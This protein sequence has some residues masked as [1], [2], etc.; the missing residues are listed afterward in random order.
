MFWGTLQN[1]GRRGEELLNKLC[2]YCFLCTQK[3]FCSFYSN[4]GWTPDVTW[5]ILLMSLLR[6]CALIVVISLLSMEGQRALRFHQKHLNLCSEDEQKSYGFGTTWGWVINDRILIFWV[7][8]PFKHNLIMQVSILTIRPR[9]EIWLEL[10]IRKSP[11]F[12]KM[13]W[14]A[15]QSLGSVSLLVCRSSSVENALGSL[16]WLKR[17][18]SVPL[19]EWQWGCSFHWLETQ[20]LCSL[21]GGTCWCQLQASRLSTHCI[22]LLGPPLR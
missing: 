14:V 22:I 1:G 2:Y 4:Y 12:L 9:K 15:G 11:C 20:V 8:Y 5:T 6:F 21:A 7:N 16:H 19:A 10:K 18:G 3:V 13:L 17:T